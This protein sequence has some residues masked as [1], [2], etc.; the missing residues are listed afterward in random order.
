MHRS[1]TADQPTADRQAADNARGAHDLPPTPANMR[2]KWLAIAA[3]EQ[4]LHKLWHTFNSD[5]GMT[6]AQ[7]VLAEWR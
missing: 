2:W 7:K 5:A 4:V 6:A 1:F 3:L